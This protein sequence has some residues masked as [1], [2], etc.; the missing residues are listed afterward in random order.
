MCGSPWHQKIMNGVPPWDSNPQPTTCGIQGFSYHIVIHAVAV[1]AAILAGLTGLFYAS[2]RDAYGR[3]LNEVL[4]HRQ[5]PE[6]WIDWL[7]QWIVD[8]RVHGD[9]ARIIEH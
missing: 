2:I 6:S 4:S 9:T 7:G 3:S 8:M 1:A 5:P